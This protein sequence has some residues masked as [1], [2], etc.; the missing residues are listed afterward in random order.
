VRD[1][2]ISCQYFFHSSHPRLR[3]S[4]EFPA[5]NAYLHL[6]LDSASYSSQANW[7]ESYRNLMGLLIEVQDLR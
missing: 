2:N 6:F 5:S 3:V 7:D 4:Q 1:A